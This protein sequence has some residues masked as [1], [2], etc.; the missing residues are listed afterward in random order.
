MWYLKKKNMYFNYYTRNNDFLVRIYLLYM[1]SFDHKVAGET[2]TRT[3]F[4]FDFLSI[5]FPHGNHNVA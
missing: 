1:N 5:D 4:H 3:Q 2:H